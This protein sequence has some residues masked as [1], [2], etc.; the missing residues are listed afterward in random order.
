VNSSPAKPGSEH[1]NEPVLAFARRDVTTLARD[2]TVE[3][4]LAA[5]RSRGWA[6][7]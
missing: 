1:L 5:I 3:Q 4:A 7:R 2:L 6:K